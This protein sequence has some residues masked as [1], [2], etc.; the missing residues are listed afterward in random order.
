MI[1]RMNIY[2]A[3]IFFGGGGGGK[4]DVICQGGKHGL[5]YSSL[6]SSYG[7]QIVL[8]KLAFPRSIC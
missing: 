3:L 6:K 7:S 4:G 2:A 8:Q 5:H 1:G